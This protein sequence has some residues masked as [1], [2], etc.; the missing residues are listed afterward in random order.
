M[1]PLEGT[2]SNSL[3]DILL[4]LIEGKGLTRRKRPLWGR[5][6]ILRR[7]Q[8][9]VGGDLIGEQQKEEPKN[10]VD[11]MKMSDEMF[12]FLCHKVRP[13]PITAYDHPLFHQFLIISHV[14]V[15][16]SQLLYKEM[17]PKW[18]LQLR[19]KRSSVSPFVF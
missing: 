19:P 5:K 16:R 1:L 14:F 2:N 17:T 6:W 13:H 15:Y 4:E 7:F 11:F 18:G 9:G 12:T 10:Y 3:V 8:P